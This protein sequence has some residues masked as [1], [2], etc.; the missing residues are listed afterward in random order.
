MNRNKSHFHVVARLPL[1]A[2][3]LSAITTA[4]GCAPNASPT[5]LDSTSDTSS[6]LGKNTP[7]AS[8]A[9][10]LVQQKKA[11]DEAVRRILGQFDA[12]EGDRIYESTLLG[13]DALV[14]QIDRLNR[15]VVIVYFKAESELGLLKAFPQ[16]RVNGNNV[17]A[18]LGAGSA[19]MTFPR[20]CQHSACIVP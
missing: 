17:W 14:F 20:G 19:E 5:A 13:H 8:Y 12:Q 4:S 6:L 2:I 18:A 9:A 3:A 15:R 11:T 16:Y 7:T 10:S 1:V